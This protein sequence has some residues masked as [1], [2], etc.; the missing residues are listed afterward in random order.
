MLD[1]R[2]DADPGKFKY[3]SGIVCGLED[4]LHEGRNNSSGEV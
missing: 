4:R 1:L 3:P 2:E